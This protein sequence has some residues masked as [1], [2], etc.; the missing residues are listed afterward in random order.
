MVQAMD[1]KMEANFAAGD[2]TRLVDALETEMLTV[3][4]VEEYRHGMLIENA[5]TAILDAFSTLQRERDRVALDAVDTFVARVNA[6]AESEIL[7]TH[8]IAGAHHRAMEAELSKIHAAR[9]VL[10]SKPEESRSP[11]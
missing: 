7:K 8:N 1:A 11:S 10:D 4:T 3:R 6:R 5:K 9:A 2:I